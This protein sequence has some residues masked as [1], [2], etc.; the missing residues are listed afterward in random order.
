MLHEDAA[1]GHPIGTMLVPRGR[2]L[3][4]RANEQR[5]QRGQ[6]ADEEHDAPAVSRVVRVGDGIDRAERERREQ[7]ADRVALLKEPGEHAAQAR[8]RE[9][10]RQRRADAPFAAHADAEEHAEQQE[11]AIA[12]RQAAQYGDHRIEDDVEHERQ[13]PAVAVGH[14]AEDN[15]AE[16]AHRQRQ[17]DRER[18]LWPRLAECRRDVV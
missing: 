17:R 3:D 18:D 2:F 8:R 7:I 10:E 11:H 6:A 16:G 4:A 14:E 9:F 13:T 5:Q 1:I 12:R 15:R